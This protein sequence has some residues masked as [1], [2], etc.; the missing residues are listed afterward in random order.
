MSTLGSTTGCNMSRAPLPDGQNS[1]N[2]QAEATTLAARARKRAR[3]SNSSNDDLQDAR[4]VTAERTNALSTP[5][6]TV[7]PKYIFAPPNTAPP[8]VSAPPAYAPPRPQT[9]GPSGE[10]VLDLI[11]SA[12]N[13]KNARDRA[14]GKTTRVISMSSQDVVDLVE[15]AKKRGPSSSKRL[16][17]THATSS[18]SQHTNAAGRASTSTAEQPRDHEQ[19]AAPV[20]D[21]AEGMDWRPTEAWDLGATSGT[22]N[23]TTPEAE[24]STP[25]HAPAAPFGPPPSAFPNAASRVAFLSAGGLAHFKNRPAVFPARHRRG[26][27]ELSDQLSAED[28]ADWDRADRNRRVV[29]RIIKQKV[30]QNEG[31]L[32]YYRDVVSGIVVAATG[33][34]GFR[35]IAPLLLNGVDRTA[36]GMAW[37]VLDLSPDATRILLEQEGWG[38]P[39]RSIVCER[40]LQMIPYFLFTIEGFRN[41]VAHP[42]KVSEIKAVLTDEGAKDIT[43]ILLLKEQHPPLDIARRAKEILNGMVVEIVDYGAKVQ[44]KKSV[45]MNVYCAPPTEDP[46]R[47]ESWRDGMKRLPFKT[48]N[49]GEGKPRSVSR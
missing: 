33:E 46:T 18:L 24:Q 10:A 22:S 15:R 11:A 44:G 43:S 5:Q 42:L 49:N 40:D 36:A 41:F 37:P 20:P 6:T 32:E 1:E 38:Y 34:T 28:L 26:P 12:L 21:T 23:D 31:D 13:E 2:G 47:W 30:M 16:E 39:G 45:V 27:H 9:P 25:T 14:C 7:D 3:T 19:H 4:L 35:L 17:Y 48:K 29:V 8:R